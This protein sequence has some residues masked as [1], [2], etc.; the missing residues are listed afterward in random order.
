MTKNSVTCKPENFLVRI[1]KHFRWYE[2]DW[3][4]QREIT[5]KNDIE[6]KLRSVQ[7]YIKDKEQEQVIDAVIRRVQNV[8]NRAD[9][10]QFHLVEYESISWKVSYFFLAENIKE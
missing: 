7:K 3:R 6:E 5:K 1:P 2:Q 8:K 9:G 4:D 10:A